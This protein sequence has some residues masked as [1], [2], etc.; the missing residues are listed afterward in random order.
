MGIR[1]LLGHEF[2]EPE[3][4]RRREE[5]G[6]E[7]I[8][9]VSEVKTCRRCGATRI[10]SENK[11]ITSIEQLAA[12]AADPAEQPI[13]QPT[14]PSTDRSQSDRSQPDRQPT[15]STP[16]ETQPPRADSPPSTESASPESPSAEDAEI[17]SNDPEPAPGDTEPAPEP[18]VSPDS[19]ATARDSGTAEPTDA[20]EAGDDPADADPA[21]TDT[22]SSLVED[23]EAG[24]AE[25]DAEILPNESDRE[26][27][28]QPGAWPT[29]EDRE[30]PASDFEST[31]WPEQTGEDAGYDA[32]TPT[33]ADEGGLTGGGGFVPDIADAEATLDRATAG[34]DDA[35]SAGDD[36]GAAGVDIA[37]A[38]TADAESAASSSGDSSS[39]A[40]VLDAEDDSPA[41]DGFIR[42]DAAGEDFE[43]IVDNVPTEFFCPDCGLAR[44]S[45]VSSMRAGDICPS[46]KRG[47]IAERPIDR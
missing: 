9:A 34:D 13:Q 23:T 16:A 4:R 22:D 45:G 31:P 1:C 41:E 10:V 40:E 28:R 19:T 5:Q 37:A 18:G 8:I 36:T 21:A 35:S 25:E 3:L 12:T 29:Y 47:Y 15:D 39:D 30:E 27:E 42:A 20:S 2:G 32:S 46:C 11:E 7:V 24:A 14:S 6:E 38:E 17:L 33:E 26:A 44:R 43:P